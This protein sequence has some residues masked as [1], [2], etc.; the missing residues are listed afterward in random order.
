MQN[1]TEITILFK[2]PIGARKTDITVD[3]K[4]S[5]I[6]LVYG[7]TPMLE[8]ELLQNVKSDESVW[9]INPHRCAV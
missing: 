1:N 3:V 7:G 8:G 2:I 4:P 5:S 6:C 9:T